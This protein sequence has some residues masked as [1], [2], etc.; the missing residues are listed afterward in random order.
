MDRKNAVRNNKNRFSP[1]LDC[2]SITETYNADHGWPVKKKPSSKIIQQRRDW[3]VIYMYDSPV[4]KIMMLSLRAG[5]NMHQFFG[6]WGL[7]FILC[8]PPTGWRV[9]IYWDGIYTVIYVWTS[10]A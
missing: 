1:Y 8:Q 10:C 2:D 4:A 5:K 7:N 6:E 3:A 9:Y